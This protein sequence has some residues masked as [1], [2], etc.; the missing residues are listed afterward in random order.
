MEV[1]LQ[2]TGAQGV[3]TRVC[4]QRQWLRMTGNVRRWQEEEVSAA[5]AQTGCG[6]D[7]ED[8]DRDLRR[9]MDGSSIE[10]GGLATVKQEDAAA[11]KREEEKARVLVRGMVDRSERAYGRIYAALPEWVTLQVAH[12]PQGYAYGLWSWLEGKFQGTD[13]D[14]VDA[15]LDEWH[16]LAQAQGEQF[17]AYRAR[18]NKVQMLLT[19]ADERPSERMYAH[20]LLMRLQPLYK[21]AVLVL[22]SGGQLKPVEVAGKDGRSVVKPVDWDKVAVFINAH[23]RSE[24][25]L[26]AGENGGPSVT[27]AQHAFATRAAWRGDKRNSGMDR[28]GGERESEHPRGSNGGGDQDRTR[29]LKDIQCFDCGGYGHMAKNCIRPSRGSRAGGAGDYRA[30]A[31]SNSYKERSDKES[32]SQATVTDRRVTFD[33]SFDPSDFGDEHDYVY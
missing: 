31:A 18:V 10:D 24:R 12:I 17:D 30:E 3:H 16:G 8:E 4:T 22:K 27:G 25:R 13:E 19:H 23:E 6:T 11:A 9:A 14:N 20:T 2:R 15:L 29:W 28:G 7:E 1:F 32:V 5:L 21:A 33:R 26:E